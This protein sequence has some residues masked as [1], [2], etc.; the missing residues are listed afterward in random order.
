MKDLDE[1]GDQDLVFAAY[2]DNEVAWYENDGTGS[3]TFRDISTSV[4]GAQAVQITDVDGDGDW[5]V[6]AAAR[7]SN[8]F[9]SFTTTANKVLRRR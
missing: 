1:D 7:D 6:L 9:L 2:Y 5:D 8:E 4:T 3:F